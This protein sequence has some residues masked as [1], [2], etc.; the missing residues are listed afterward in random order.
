[1]LVITETPILEATTPEELMA[2]RSLYVDYAE[3]TDSPDCS[4]EYEL[5]EMTS[6][7]L[8][9]FYMESGEPIAVVQAVLGHTEGSVHLQRLR[10]AE[11]HRRLGIA[12]RLCQ[13]VETFAAS[14]GIGVVSLSV[15]EP[16]SGAL[17]MYKERGYEEV[18]RYPNSWR[19]GKPI[20]NIDLVK[21]VS[22]R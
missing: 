16:N 18:A 15:E 8:K 6:G 2:V 1:M 20:I 5:Q 17:K 22:Q 7:N 12:S 19:T 21:D 3:R 9:P 10:V 13:R 11:T 4:F 14:V